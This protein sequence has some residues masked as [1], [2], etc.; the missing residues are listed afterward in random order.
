MDELNCKSVRRSLW[1]YM[2][3]SAEP[4][5][6][7]GS[8]SSREIA[9]HLGGCRDC[10]LHG[11]DVRPLRSGLK[12]LPLMHVP[13]IL[14][15]R[16][17]I[18]ASRERV[19]LLAR[20]DLQTFLHEIGSLARLFFDNLLR[21]FAVPA[22]GGLLASFLCF[23]V[24]VGTLQVAPDW[25]DDMPI[26]WFTEVMIDEP[27]PFSFNGRDV[28]VQL[29]V[30]SGG[31]VTDYALPQERNPLP[32]ELQEIGNLVR[33]TSFTPARRFG[34]P[35]ASKRLFLIRHISIKG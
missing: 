33:F 31:Q 30:D 35:I 12:H 23:G 18:L 26:G 13:P 34:Q 10:R 5:D 14:T 25:Q 16:L 3:G 4:G 21:P 22:A 6:P 9:L 15:T 8:P 27:S 1:D 2:A 11:A 19:R 32:D 20:R 24:I 28:M 29:T 17:Q 7:A